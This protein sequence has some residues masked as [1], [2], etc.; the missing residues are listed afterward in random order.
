[1]THSK[2]NSNLQSKVNRITSGF[3]TLSIVLQPLSPASLWISSRD[4]RP[5]RRH[6]SLPAS[7]SHLAAIPIPNSATSA[8]SRYWHCTGGIR[9]EMARLILDQKI[10]AA[11]SVEFFF[12][13]DR[14]RHC[15][16]SLRKQLSQ[17]PDLF[18]A[19]F[20]RKAS[21]FSSVVQPPVVCFEE[22]NHCF[23]FSDF[24]GVKRD[25][26]VL[27]SQQFGVVLLG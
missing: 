11:A 4:S 6:P 17:S 3:S 24:K 20:T 2:S 16:G 1:M 7:E 22:I 9:C 25:V 15:L 8:L 27:A 12:S 13:F 26:V 23:L 18:F 21:E 19:C 5:R 10:E 14:S